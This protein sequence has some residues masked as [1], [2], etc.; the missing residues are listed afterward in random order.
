MTDGTPT[1]R[2]AVGAFVPMSV[3][4]SAT[5]ATIAAARV[6]PFDWIRAA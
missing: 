1:S 2:P 3:V 4:T 5:V 6:A